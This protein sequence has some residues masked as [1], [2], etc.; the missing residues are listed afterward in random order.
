MTGTTQELTFGCVIITNQ[1]VSQSL[2]PVHKCVQIR[3]LTNCIHIHNQLESY[4]EQMPLLKI[5]GSYMVSDMD[6]IVV[7]PIDGVPF[8]ICI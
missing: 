6:H 1:K 4:V 5:H 2:Y 7:W 3:G 8:M